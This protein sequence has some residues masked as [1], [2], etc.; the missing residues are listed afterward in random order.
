MSSLFDEN[1]LVVIHGASGQGK[2]ALAYRFALENISLN[3]G[4]EL[5]LSQDFYSNRKVLQ[6]L[7]S[8]AKSFSFP[9][10]VLI[11]IPP[12]MSDW[13][14]LLA[15]IELNFGFRILVTIRS[16]DWNNSNEVGAY[17][18]YGELSL[19]FYQEEA[20]Q[21][22][23]NLNKIKPDKRF[24][25]F[26][27]SWESFG[28][29]GPLLEYVFLITQGDAL[30]S[31]IKSQV[32][33]LKSKFKQEG[34]SDGMFLLRTVALADFLGAKI[35]LQKFLIA[36]TFPELQATIETFQ[37]EY[38]IHFSAEGNHLEGLHPI[39]SKMLC[40]FIFDDFQYKVEEFLF[41]CLRV[42][43]TS[44]V[45]VVIMAY[46]L[47]YNKN[48]KLAPS[49][50]EKLNPNSWEEA[51]KYL[52]ALFWKG[53]QEYVEENKKPISNAYQQVGDGWSL[54]LPI[55]ITGA[56]F[57]VPFVQTSDQFSEEAKQISRTLSGNFTN[58]SRVFN[59]GKNF[60]LKIE[61]KSLRL[62]N[63][64]DCFYLGET[65]FWKGYLDLLEKNQFDF[66]SELI[67]SCFSED[68]AS[69]ISGL[70]KVE[71]SNIS[72]ISH[73]ES[74]LLQKLKTEFEIPSI[75]RLEK[76][77]E[78][79][80][81][82]GVL[83]GTHNKRTLKEGSLHNFRNKVLSLLAIAFPDLDE[84]KSQ[85][86]GH[87]I[88]FLSVGIDEST[89]STIPSSW[90][91]DRLST[92]NHIFTNLIRNFF[93]PRSWEDY[94]VGIVDY[95]K[96]LLL[97]AKEIKEGY[98]AVTSIP[99]KPFKLVEFSKKNME[100]SL[101]QQSIPSLPISIVDP[102]GRVSEY[103]SEAGGNKV[104]SNLSAQ[105][106]QKKQ[107]DS[108]LGSVSQYKRY[109]EIQKSYF[110][111][112]ENFINQSWSIFQGD[113]KQRKDLAAFNLQKAWQNLIPF[114]EIFR[115]DYLKFSSPKELSRLEFNE[116]KALEDM[117]FFLEEIDLKNGEVIRIKKKAKRDLKSAEVKIL[118]QLQREIEALEKEKGWEIELIEGDDE[119]TG[120]LL[121]FA[122]V[123]N[124]LDHTDSQREIWNVL[125]KT[126]A[127]LK[128][129]RLYSTLLNGPFGEAR[130]IT[131][132]RDRLLIEDHLVAN[133]WNII[134]YDYGKAPLFE[135]YI[136]PIDP[137]FAVKY[138]LTLW[139]R[140][141]LS[142]KEWRLTVIK[143]RELE[144]SLR[145]YIAT[146]KEFIKGNLDIIGE[147]ITS[148]HLTIIQGKIEDNWNDILDFLEKIL[149]KGKEFPENIQNDQDLQTATQLLK[150][151]YS[152]LN[153]SE[154]QANEGFFIDVGF[155]ENWISSLPIAI[156]NLGVLFY[157]FSGRLIEGYRN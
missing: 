60:L 125:R 62:E 91:D 55:D 71:W 144:Y 3:A 142:I 136:N 123:F 118:H 64:R 33:R 89:G 72:M 78:I 2:S 108:F 82:V 126:L 148:S 111:H 44:N 129:K 88:G 76:S 154:L 107:E 99:R 68:L 12:G 97:W 120:S 153:P 90:P 25:T 74:R 18:K 26:N 114:Q 1:N 47:H 132:F 124:A 80:F 73:L 106:N 21:L 105:G 94:V 5:V 87:Q 119:N 58:P 84:I 113:F 140:Q 146:A 138:D 101:I 112:F 36:F 41:R 35:D 37:R 34:N 145:H 66:Y 56:F 39:R 83:E 110:R 103:S 48:S 152:L 23:Q 63:N 4:F 102:F 24:R 86:Y 130:I 139:A 15:K 53:I 16:E 143:A 121:I 31:R 150:E 11:D 57:Q 9:L 137:E 51:G 50:I 85:G 131:L 29:S 81:I 52:K 122:N 30:K 135:F 54:F 22:Y 141:F 20:K 133:S 96:Q 59:L 104:S 38:L 109:R 75:T 100:R 95:R 127:P 134:D 70:K 27:E 93:R 117:V 43:A 28:E 147:K 98:M 45:E 65:L 19:D 116:R 151:S 8:L 49:F 32:K 67:E 46:F 42:I 92:L 7:S 40:D 13:P 10:L 149:S 156:H 115:K 128:N 155:A 157:F 17:F 14:K 61:G 69:L 6:G 77:I 79:K